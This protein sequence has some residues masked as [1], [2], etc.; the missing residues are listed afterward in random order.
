VTGG[1]RPTVELDGGLFRPSWSP[2]GALLALESEPVVVNPSDGRRQA[3]PRPAGVELTGAWLADGSGWVATQT[4]G[5]E[6]TA[7][8][9]SADGRFAPGAAASF[10]V[11]GLE[12]TIGADG[13]T[14]SMAV[15]DGATESDTAIVEL[16]VGLDSTCSCRAWARFVTPGSDP[17]FGYAV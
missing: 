7:G 13:G 4:A 16:R 6:T 10:E 12:R 1:G 17:Q 3:I 5:E 2:S 8:S 14:L 15:S 11:T 9:L